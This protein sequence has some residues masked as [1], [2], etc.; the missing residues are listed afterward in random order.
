MIMVP[1]S[2]ENI[3]SRCSFRR[4][5]L[6]ISCSQMV[7]GTRQKILD[8]RQRACYQKKV[9]EFSGAGC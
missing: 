6:Q 9:V 7:A 3:W 1:S 4:G 2:L 8:Q 5:R